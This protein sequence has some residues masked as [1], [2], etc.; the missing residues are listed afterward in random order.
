[1]LFDCNILKGKNVA[2][3]GAT[4]GIGRATAILLSS[5]GANLLIGSRS[6]KELEELSAILPTKVIPQQLNIE[7]ERSITNFLNEG[8]L[9]FGKID[10]L[11]NCAGYGSFSSFLEL[12]IEEFDRMISV[13]LRGSFLASQYFAKHM[14]KNKRGQINNINSI[15]GTATLE[16]NAGYSASKFGLLGLSRVMQLELRKQ[17][18]Y[19]T[20]V[21]PGS[22]NTQFWDHIENH[23]EK[24]KMI[25][26]ETIAK[27]IAAILCQPDGAVIDEITIMPPL[28]IL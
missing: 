18:V 25:P 26:Q 9:K 4:K 24:S 23:P 10:A 19:V 21:L 13:N 28:G 11:V 20:S 8:V 3:T 6:V 15:A 2:I 14:I 12:P 1:M 7:D 17:G 5:K 27:H 16:G 22:T